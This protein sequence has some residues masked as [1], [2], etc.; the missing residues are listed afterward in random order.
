MKENFIIII[1]INDTFFFL[2]LR[3]FLKMVS[4]LAGSDVNILVCS[5]L[6][7]FPCTN[8]TPKVAVPLLDLP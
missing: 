1:I 2:A 4:R 6:T 5:Y 3:Q 7:I 8:S